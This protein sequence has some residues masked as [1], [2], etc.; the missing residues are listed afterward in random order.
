MSHILAIEPDRRQAARLNAIARVP[1]NVELVVADTAEAALAAISKRVPDLILTSRLLS[2]K[3][4]AMLDGRLR[5]LDAANWNVQTLMIPMLAGGSSKGGGKKAGGLLNRLRNSGEDDPSGGCD[6]MVFA[7]EINEYLERAAA[8]RALKAIA[9][10]DELEMSRPE[11]PPAD[12][13]AQH[14]H[15]TAAASAALEGSIGVMPQLELIT[16]PHVHHEAAGR[17]RQETWQEVSLDEHMNVP[18]PVPAEEPDTLPPAAMS[19]TDR[20]DTIVEEFVAGQDQWAPPADSSSGA[21]RKP[22]LT[23]KRGDDEWGFFDPQKI[24]FAALLEELQEA[25][26]G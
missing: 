13:P 20:P 5:E 12:E 16:E 7:E 14:D 18:A 21:S 10:E 6:P 2:P 26:A 9:Q 3:D 23:I 24:G 1:L 11:P 15:E 25:T 17:A 4:E 22:A 8:E 19:A